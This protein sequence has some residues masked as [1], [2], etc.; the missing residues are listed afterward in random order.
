MPS[1]CYFA[2]QG[3]HETMP[4]GLAFAD[5]G[6]KAKDGGRFMFMPEKFELSEI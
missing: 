1:N 3:S 4:I 6:F 2:Y 5:I